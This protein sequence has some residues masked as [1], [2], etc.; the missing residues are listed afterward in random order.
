MVQTT[1]QWNTDERAVAEGMLTASP[2]V[3]ELTLLIPCLNEAETI[4]R[5]VTKAVDLLR[6]EGL[7]GEVLVADNGST[8]GSQ[9]LAAEAGARVIHM[10]VRGYGAALIAGI[11]AAYGRYIIMGDA[12]DSYD[13]SAVMPFI[14]KLREGCDLVMGSRMKGRILPGA[15]PWLHRWVGNPL[16]TAIGNLLFKTHIS[17]YHCGLRGF[18]AETARALQPR[19]T[20]MEFATELIAKMALNRRTITEIPITY[21]PDG[22]SRRPHLRTWRD[23][24][25]HLKFML[26]LSP[27]WVFIQ[28]GAVLFLLGLAGLTWSL[29]SGGSAGMTFNSQLA[30]QISF[31]ILTL[32]GSQILIFGVLARLYANKMGLL[33]STR[34]W[35][36]L[37]DALSVDTGLVVGG[38]VSLLGVVGLIRAL[39]FSDLSGLLI[40]LLVLV[41]GTKQV[42][43]SFVV[44]LIRIKESFE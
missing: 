31:S 20:G 4:Q 26:L 7:A 39:Q 1:T 42:F 19:T 9:G 28:P 40:G 43:V 5:V 13:F 32:I 25:R 36:W 22:R 6:S 41:F 18:N 15:M 35:H 33:P 8:D 17:D 12:D 3:L 11:H 24:W 29:L 44:S 10:P 37:E 23:G 2:T 14:N 34:F 38:A 30:A 16:L 27:T 21:Y